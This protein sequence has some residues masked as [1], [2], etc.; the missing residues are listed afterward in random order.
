MFLN[1][2]LNYTYY[3]GDIPGTAVVNVTINTRTFDLT[4][5]ENS[6]EVAILGADVNT[7]VYDATIR[8]D[9]PFFEGKTVMTFGINITPA[10]NTFLVEWTPF[11]R[12]ISYA[13][14]VSIAVVYTH[15]YEPVL[16]ANVTLTIN[17]TMLHTL[18][19]SAID[20]KWHISFDATYIELG[21]WNFTVRANKTG[22]ASGASWYIVSVEEDSP[23]LTPSFILAQLDY[24]SSVILQIDVDSS[25]GSA[26]DDATVEVT[27]LGIAAT[28]MHIGSGIYNTSFGPYLD[29]GFHSINITFYRFGFRT[30]SIFINLNVTAADAA[31]I[32][33]NTPLTIYYDEFVNLNASY[34]MANMSNIQGEKF[35]ITVN[36]TD[37][38]FIWSINHWEATFV[39][40]SLGLGASICFV[41]V[42]AYGFRS[43]NAT[44][45]I[46]IQAIPTLMTIGPSGSTYV[47]STYSFIVTYEDTRTST[48]IDADIIS[49]IW[50]GTYWTN[51]LGVGQYQIHLNADLHNGTH[52]FLLNLVKS[53]HFGASTNQSIDVLPIPVEIVHE[54]SIEEYESELLM[55]TVYLNDTIYNRPVHWAS[56]ELTFSGSDLAMSY[57]HSTS[58]YEVQI[59]LD[60][61]QPGEYTLYIRSTAIDCETPLGIISLTILPKDT[62]TLTLAT[63][64]DELEAG[65]ILYL[66]ATLMNDG[67]PVPGADVYF[68]L[69]LFQ[70]DGGSQE[71]TLSGT[72]NGA[73]IAAAE[74]EVPEGTTSIQINSEFHGSRSAWAAASGVSSIVIRQPSTTPIGILALLSDPMVQLILGAAVVALVGVGYSKSR[75][76][77][78]TPINS[79]SILL[80]IGGL[81]GVRHCI[82]YNADKRSHILAK[83]YMATGQDSYIIRAL[84]DLAGVGL[85][86]NEIPGFTFEMSLHGFKVF[87]YRGK[88]IA[89]VLTAYDAEK[90]QYKE[91]L[92]LLVDTFEEQYEMELPDWPKNISVYG[93][94]W[95]II[96]PDAS[97]SERI[98]A[99]VFSLEEGAIRAEIANRLN[100]PVNKVSKIVKQILNTDPDFQDIRVGRKKIV[101]FR[102]ALNDEI[103]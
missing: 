90:V 33:D 38:A 72:T 47:N 19:Y 39:G 16:G 92:Q 42:D 101:A 44:F 29:L 40:T 82:L 27:L 94:V 93:D 67:S 89:G 69:T 46:I 61:T 86:G 98:K 3:G 62:Y 14:N 74:F 84:E 11:D 24:L 58:S 7:G 48:Y 63:S 43:L 71:V 32:L 52:F 99:L 83:S 95:R 65:D 97:D 23:S 54:S 5:V 80:G 9:Y 88:L 77:P 73:G 18:L 37:Y 1:L 78:K 41:T 100:M 81:T 51:Q 55:I 64:P 53:G 2:T 15:D 60:A 8:A 79:S 4:Y 49:I 102:S 30:T 76:K 10:A 50:P 87:I 26:I 56:V 35:K 20:E 22:Y 13:E 28:T 103:S 21:Y 59:S 45:T 25:N 68:T 66:T 91:N 57:S 75:R 36:T 17:G 85:R 96:G 31:L 70:D 6:W 12:N 34:L